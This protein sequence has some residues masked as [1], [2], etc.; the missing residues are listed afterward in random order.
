M[1][2]SISMKRG[3]F[4][5]VLIVV[6]TLS[7]HSEERKRIAVLDFGAKGV[8][9]ELAGAIVENFITSLVDSGEYDVI[10]RSQLQKLMNELSLQNSDD[11][12]D[13]LR[14][15]LGNLYGAEMVMLGSITK[16]GK[17]I[18]INVRGVEVATGIARF[19]KKVS[20]E[21]E[22]NIPELLDKL[23][24][25]ILGKAH[26]RILTV[27]TTDK[28]NKTT[29]T[30]TTT[31]RDIRMRNAFLGAK[32]GMIVSAAILIPTTSISLLAGVILVPIY[33]TNRFMSSFSFGANQVLIANNIQTAMIVTLVVGGVTF[34]LAIVSGVLAGYFKKR[35]QSVLIDIPGRT[36]PM[37]LNFDYG[38]RGDG[39]K[40]GIA[41]AL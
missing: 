19:A 1:Q 41:L 28:T 16:I 5:C 15:Q 35:E 9:N 34:P 40:V 26:D 32:V 24:L 6:L 18:T 2:W 3:V 31:T 10:E 39:F 8:K 4:L 27:K 23:V 11:F 12:N 14:E 20:T 33:L 13:D 37:A 36:L 21:S 29:S 7:L 38:F 22:E 30:T 17:T 25:V